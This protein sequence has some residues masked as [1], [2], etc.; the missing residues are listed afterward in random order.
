MEIYLVINP[1][2]DKENLRR[3]EVFRSFQDA[4]EYIWSEANFWEDKWDWW[5]QEHE[6]KKETFIFTDNVNSFYKVA[7]ILTKEVR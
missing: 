7:Y 2:F 4:E 5:R 6:E 3:Y 1:F